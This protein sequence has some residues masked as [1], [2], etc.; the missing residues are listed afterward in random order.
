MAGMTPLP[1]TVIHSSQRLSHRQAY[2]HLS[3]FLEEAD[4]N[5]AYR[6]DAVLTSHGP[7]ASGVGSHSNLTLNHLHRILKG[8][9]GERIGGVDFNYGQGP[10][11]KRRKVDGQVE[12]NSSPPETQNGQK[13]SEKVMGAEDEDG[14]DQAAIVGQE[15]GDWQDKEDF[16]HAQVDETQDL[17]ERDMA[18]AGT[19]DGTLEAVEVGSTTGGLSKADKM[20]RKAAKQ[21]RRK[22][23][24]K[25]RNTKTK[26]SER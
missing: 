22:Q 19:V 18:D 23:E 16:E 1:Q 20:A 5:P 4:T 2:D 9:A 14:A 7:T 21:A 6:P 12:M 13:D 8:I 10:P 17:R 15:T 26:D 25:D 24:K 3:S 11:R